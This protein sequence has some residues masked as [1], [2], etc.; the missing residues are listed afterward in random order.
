MSASLLLYLDAEGK[1]SFDPTKIRN[2]LKH[3]E[4]MSNW[5]E[6]SDTPR[7]DMLFDCF[8]EFNGDSTIVFVP[9]QL[10]FVGVWGTGDASLQVA[11]E[12]QKRYD[13]PIYIAV[14]ESPDNVVNLTTVLSLL[15]LKNRLNR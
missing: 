15:D 5:R 6:G 4:G 2:C 13:A 12:I 1:V 9:P 7:D 10:S 3:L 8:Y 14:S 11:L